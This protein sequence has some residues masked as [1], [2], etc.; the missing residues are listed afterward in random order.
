MT[1]GTIEDSRLK[2]GLLTIDAHEF[3]KQMTTVT[4]EPSE[5]EEGERVET[6]SGAT[7]EPDEVTSWELNL[8]AIQDFT[9]PDGFVEFARANKG[10]IVPF[11]WQPNGEGPSY[12]GMCRVRAV[13]IGG[14]VA[15]RLNTTKA[16]PVI[17]E[18]TPAYP[19]FG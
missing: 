5:S 4:L 9:D 11:V 17:G 6:L 19:A 12:T 14:E 1:V 15:A 16:W 3:A 7:S 18:P 13:T 2:G 8:G 10:E